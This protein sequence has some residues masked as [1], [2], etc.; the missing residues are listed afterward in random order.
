MRPVLKNVDP[1]LTVTEYSEYRS[2]LTS[3]LGYYCSYCERRLEHGIEIEHIRPKTLY[4]DLE[5][6]WENLLI[7]CRNCNAIKGHKDVILDEFIW[8]HLDNTAMAYQYST[9]GIVR[10]STNLNDTQKEKAKKLMDLVGLDRVPS[11]DISKNPEER[12]NRWKFRMTA[13]DKAEELKRDLM[14]FDTPTMRKYIIEIAVKTGYFSVWM[15]VFQSDLKMKKDLIAAFIG[16][17]INCY[18]PA[19]FD[20]ISRGSL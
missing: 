20:Y 16:T 18:D 8:P 17:D 5:L 9:G 7:A 4:E 6:K 13:W 3:N 2:H 11:L 10:V 15:S 12:D 19:T 14:S 1:N